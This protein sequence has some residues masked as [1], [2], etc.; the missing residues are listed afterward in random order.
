MFRDFKKTPCVCGTYCTDGL[1][2]SLVI[3]DFCNNTFHAHCIGIT[4]P[5]LLLNI[6]SFQCF[7]CTGSKEPTEG[8]FFCNDNVAKAKQT[9]MK[10]RMEM[11]EKERKKIAPILAER[12][13]NFKKKQEIVI[14]EKSADTFKCSLVDPDAEHL[15]NIYFETEKFPYQN[16]LAFIFGN[17]NPG[18]LSKKKE[19]I[20]YNSLKTFRDLIENDLV[21]LSKDEIIQNREKNFFNDNFYEKRKKFFNLLH[22]YLGKKIALEMELFLLRKNNFAF[23]KTYNEKLVEILQILKN[24]E[25]VVSMLN[26]ETLSVEDF[27]SKNASE[28]ANEKIKQET[29]DVQRKITQEKIITCDNEF[30][31]L[32][33]DEMFQSTNDDTP[34]EFS[35]S[36]SKSTDSKPTTNTSF[37]FDIRVRSTNFCKGFDIHA[38]EIQ[39]MLLDNAEISSLFMEHHL[40]IQKGLYSLRNVSIDGKIGVDSV[41]AYIYSI[42]YSRKKIFICFKIFPSK[43]SEKAEHFE[44]FRQAMVKCKRAAVIDK[45]KTHGFVLYI[46]PFLNNKKY[47]EV[48]P[49]GGC[50]YNDIAAMIG[51]QGTDSSYDYAFGL[52]VY[53]YE[54]IPPILPR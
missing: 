8:I 42:L 18:V 35:K 47:I 29:E 4:D 32:S 19:N 20:L 53:D 15:I 11:L 2:S 14:P 33:T 25:D 26:S 21:Y 41:L 49:I 38:R 43:N 12:T 13:Q 23:T 39:Y 52:L 54:W 10:Y 40:E 31:N 45:E 5:D 27:L 1:G 6:T 9:M 24:N 48:E 37:F 17:K 16:I 7:K 30:Y 3:C 34:K 50:F 36:R 44:E 28:F 22:K 51:L 46:L